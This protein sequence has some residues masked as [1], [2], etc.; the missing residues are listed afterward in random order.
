MSVNRIVNAIRDVQASILVDIT[1]DRKYRM[2][3]VIT[4]DA[5]AIYKAFGLERKLKILPI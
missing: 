4:G 2:P 5:E 3:S 1:D